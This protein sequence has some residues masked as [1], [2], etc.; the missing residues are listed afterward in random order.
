MLRQVARVS[1]CSG[2]LRG[3]ALHA[4]SMTRRSKDASADT[5]YTSDLG[6]STVTSLVL[7]SLV[8][9]GKLGDRSKVRAPGSETIPAPRDDEAILFIAFLDAGLQIPCDAL[10]Y[11]VLRLYNVE[12]A[13]LTPNSIVK[14]GIFEW[15]LR[16]A[17]V[18]VEGGEVGEGRL[19]AY[20]H[21]GRCQPKKKK[22]TG[23][24]LNF[25]SVNFQAKSRL[26][27]YLPTPA[28]RNRWDTDWTRKWFY[29][30]SPAKHGLR[31]NCGLIQLVATPEVTLNSREDALLHVLLENDEAAV[32]PGP[33]GGVLR[34]PN[35]AFGQGLKIGT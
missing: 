13:Q 17:D 2:K 16:S 4:L 33:G 26:Q 28:A 9:E 30:T 14:L 32:H 27:M 19:F 5:A 35:M 7:D 18:V 8:S 31:S 24:T 20:L 11:E 34:F 10:V 3:L 1:L 29:H 23:E 25:G 12:L 15:M 21:D 6:R 22:S